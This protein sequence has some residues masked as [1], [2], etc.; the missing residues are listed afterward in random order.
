MGKSQRCYK[1]TRPGGFLTLYFI[2]SMVD[3]S[4]QYKAAKTDIEFKMK[5]KSWKGFKG[6]C[7]I[8]I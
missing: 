7:R 8:C 6:N 3:E 5:I 2:F 1:V 4:D